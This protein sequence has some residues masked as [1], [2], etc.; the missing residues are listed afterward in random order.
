[1][2]AR[3][4][5][6]VFAALGLAGCGPSES[7]RPDTAV[8]MSPDASIAGRSIGAWTEEWWR[9]TFDVPAAQNPELVLDADC[10]V[11]QDDPVFFVPA[12]DGSK[13]FQRTCVMPEDTTALVP[14]RVIINDYPCPDP[15]F[16]PAAGQSLEDFLKQGAI[17]YNNLVKDMAVTVDGTSVDFA[18]HRHTTGIFDFQA[19][20]SLVG[21]LPDPCLNG[22]KQS[23]VSDGFWFALTLSGGE[24]EVR[25]TGKDP[26]GESF[27]STYVLKTKPR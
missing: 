25:I 7:D 10:A 12:Y 26:E 3:S 20:A 1:M 13:V 11:G 6:L 22:M 9:W 19:E 2:K 5:V 15:S 8:V 14:L 27:D 18:A 17:D 21:A 24:H 16:E 23:G 4:S